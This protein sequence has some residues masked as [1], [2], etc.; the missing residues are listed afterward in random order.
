MVDIA[1]SGG[2]VTAVAERPGSGATRGGGLRLGLAWN[3][4]ITRQEPRELRRLYDEIVDTIVLAEELGIDSVWVAQHHFDQQPGGLPSPLVLLALAAARTSRI[5]LGTGITILP[6]E[7]PIRLAEDAAVVDLIADG[8]LELGL[9]TGGANFGA[10]AA[11]AHDPADRRTL[12]DARLARLHAALDGRSLVAEEDG[13]R[14]SPSGAGLRARLWQAATTT[15]W[16]EA[17]ARAGDGIQLGTFSDPAAGGQRPKV[18]AYLAEWERQG[19]AAPPRVALFRFLHLGDSKDE[20]VRRAEPVLG[21]RLETLGKVAA[22]HGNPEIARYTTRDFLENIAFYGTP[23]D[24]AEQFRDDP[25]DPLRTASDLV[26]NFNHWA[27][28]DA[29]RH[30][31]ELRVLV[32][33]ISPLLGRRPAA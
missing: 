2:P 3:F 22:E 23:A 30:H 10:Y 11:F 33:E 16:A 15:D 6:L 17:A 26:V 8:R 21:P 1:S 4:P 31:A 5:T 13:P 24:I 32:D 27:D 28:F 20:V 19:H 7:D 25:T 9:A 29:A 18:D 12:F 14:L